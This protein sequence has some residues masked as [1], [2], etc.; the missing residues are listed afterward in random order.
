MSEK[1]LNSYRF[2]SGQEPTD[3]MLLAIMTEANNI[4]IKKAY[5]AQQKY[6]ADY[7]FQYNLALKKWK[8]RI[9]SVRDGNL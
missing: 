1:E 3:E 9:S 6:E 5:E 4:V 8:H 7:E 2:N